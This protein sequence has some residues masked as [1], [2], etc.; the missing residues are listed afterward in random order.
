VIDARGRDG[1][2]RSYLPIATVNAMVELVRGGVLRRVVAPPPPPGF[3]EP[4]ARTR[5][6]SRR[7]SG[8]GPADKPVF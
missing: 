5:K 8:A 3:G 7:L 6:T 1:S 4:S 2:P